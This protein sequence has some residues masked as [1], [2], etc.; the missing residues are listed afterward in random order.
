MAAK[1]KKATA[2]KKASPK[3]AKKPAA[4][5]VAHAKAKTSA[6]RA[7]AEVMAHTTVDPWMK[8]E[9]ERL[10]A[11]IEKTTHHEMKDFDARWEAAGAI[12]DHEPPLFCVHNIKSTT[13]FYRDVMHEEPRNAQRFVRVARFATPMEEE[14]YGITKLDAAI[15]FIEAKIGHKIEHPPIPIAFE[16]VRI[17]VG[18]HVK[19]L[20]DATLDEIHAATKELGALHGKSHKHAVHTGIEK[21]ISK[22]GSLENVTVTERGGLLSFKGVPIAALT[23][24]LRALTHVNAKLGAKK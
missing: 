3:A 6:Q 20:R 18:S 9:Y 11:V 23:H 1:K 22:I 10:L 2:K 12:V 21:E 19:T 13:D 17:P 5:K 15:S 14:F 24:F 8:A 16:L 7:A 4:K